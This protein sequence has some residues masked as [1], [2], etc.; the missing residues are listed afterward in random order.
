[1]LAI[2]QV[3]LSPFFHHLSSTNM[4]RRRRRR[5][6]RLLSALVFFKFSLLPAASNP[7]Q[8]YTTVG[9]GEKCEPFGVGPRIFHFTTVHNDRNG[10]I[11]SYI[12]HCYAIISSLARVVGL[13]SGQKG[14]HLII[15]TNN[16]TRT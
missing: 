4:R 11:T 1:M 6:C 2:V 13:Q 7:Q 3:D 8:Q 9:F 16:I 14:S 10:H 12:F 5:Y 15:D